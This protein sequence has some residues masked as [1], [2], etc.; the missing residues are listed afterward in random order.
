MELIAF[1]RRR[2]GAVAPKE[3]DFDQHLPHTQSGKVMRRVLKARELGLDAGDVS[4]MGG[5]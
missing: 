5:V 2:L 3:I 4:T 1:G